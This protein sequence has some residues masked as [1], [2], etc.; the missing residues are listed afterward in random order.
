M[1]SADPHV[2]TELAVVEGDFSYRRRLA[3]ALHSL[4][5]GD[6]SE[7]SA[8]MSPISMDK[9]AQYATS[10]VITRISNLLQTA[11]Q[12]APSVHLICLYESQADASTALALRASGV[13]HVEATPRRIA[14][15][16]D[17]VL[18]GSLVLPLILQTTLQQIA[19]PGGQLLT[20][21]DLNL[22]RGL[23]RGGSL[24]QLADDIGFSERH[25]RR[26]TAALCLRLGVSNRVEAV[27]LAAE[28]GWV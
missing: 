21:E 9:L 15:A 6:V 5:L 16:A 20:P 13:L 11:G 7:H 10:L 8:P 1:A 22:L 19:A 26:R 25:L 18:D 12:E 2:H 14:V 23:K 28:Q 24:T 27:A 4:Q 3:R 17:A